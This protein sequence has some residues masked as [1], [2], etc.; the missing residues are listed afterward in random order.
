MFEYQHLALEGNNGLID[1]ISVDFKKVWDINSVNPLLSFGAVMGEWNC[2][3]AL[4]MTY[5][6]LMISACVYMC[7]IIWQ[8]KLDLKQ[9]KN[10]FNSLK[11]FF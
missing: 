3:V 8:M 9:W 7:V 5:L 2:T 11:A 4:L 10:S 1:L 6:Q